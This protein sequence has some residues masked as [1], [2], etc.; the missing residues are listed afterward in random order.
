[1]TM[2]RQEARNCKD[3]VSRGLSD[4]C[5]SEGSAFSFSG[6]PGGWSA[7]LCHSPLQP[8]PMFSLKPTGF[9]N[10]AAFG[11]EPDLSNYGAQ[12]LKNK[13]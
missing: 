2:G 7:G 6:A 10:V 12:D 9:A 8:S 4:S 1:M 5:K 13:I 3:L 11:G